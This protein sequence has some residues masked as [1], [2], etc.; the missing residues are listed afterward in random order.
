[1]CFACQLTAQPIGQSLSCHQGRLV[2]PQTSDATKQAIPALTNHRERVAPL[3]RTAQRC[4]S[5]ASARP[6]RRGRQRDE[7]WL[8]RVGE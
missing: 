1:M 7:L 5:I 8:K 6:R 2:V 4:T 3:S